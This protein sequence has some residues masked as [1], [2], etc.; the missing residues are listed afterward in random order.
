MLETAMFSPTITM[1]ENRKENENIV[2]RVYDEVSLSDN[3][4]DPELVNHDSVKLS[5][6]SQSRCLEV[7]KDFFTSVRDA[8]PDYRLFVD[9]F[10][11]KGDKV[12]A[13]YTISGTQTGSFLGLTPTRQRMTVSGIH[14]FRLNNGEVIEYWDAAQKIEALRNN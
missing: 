3:R 5:A 9:N 13:R 12:L 1:T 4:T 7:L 14:V 2:R 11:V 8:F 10:K 6:Y